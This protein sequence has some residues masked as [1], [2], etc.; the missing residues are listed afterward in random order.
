M[1]LRTN[2][3]NSKAIVWLENSDKLGLSSI[4]NP[5]FSNS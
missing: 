1:I 3:V 2:T 4:R 5:K